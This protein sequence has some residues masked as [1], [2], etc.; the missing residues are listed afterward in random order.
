MNT[1]YNTSTSNA[2]DTFII[3]SAALADQRHL[4]EWDLLSSILADAHTLL[5]VA[6]AEGVEPGLFH[7]GDLRTIFCTALVTHDLGAAAVRQMVR[8]ALQ[9]YGQWDATTPHWFRGGLHSEQTLDAIFG[10]YPKCEP[11]VQTA[12]RKLWAI[13]NRQILAQD[14][15]VRAERLLRSDETLADELAKVAEVKA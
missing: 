3:L 2:T 12:A 5:G 15:L 1:S 14:Y 9:K 6:C 11:A 10:G 4:A 7:S 13:H 8:T